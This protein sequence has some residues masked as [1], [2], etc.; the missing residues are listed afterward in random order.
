MA[1]LLQGP[2][3]RQPLPRMSQLPPTHPWELYVSMV[4]PTPKG[5][6][7]RGEKMVRDS[8]GYG[9]ARH[10]SRKSRTYVS[11]DLLAFCL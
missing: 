6:V 2:P 5:G 4:S 8:G 3:V 11:I 7:V 1:N 9:G 10:E